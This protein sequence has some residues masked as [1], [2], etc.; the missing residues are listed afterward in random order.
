MGVG[1]SECVLLALFFGALFGTQV[2]I[3]IG[4][5]FGRRR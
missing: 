3:S 4:G 1:L 5:L 2:T